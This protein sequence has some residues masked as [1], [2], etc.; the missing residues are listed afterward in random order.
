LTVVGGEGDTFV[1]ET[2]WVETPS[3]IYYRFTF[4]EDRSMDTVTQYVLP[5]FGGNPE[6]IKVKAR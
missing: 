2:R 1:I 6:P 3:N 5:G 4:S